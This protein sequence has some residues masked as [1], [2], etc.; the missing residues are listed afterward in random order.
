MS[1]LGSLLL[2]DQPIQE[3][4]ADFRS[5]GE[6]KIGGECANSLANGLRLARLALLQYPITDRVDVLLLFLFAQHYIE[7]LFTAISITTS[8]SISKSHH[9]NKNTMFSITY[10]PFTTI[11]SL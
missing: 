6:Y 11:P 4:M 10:F 3:L 9:D 2:D 5:D 7:L 1:K 8:I